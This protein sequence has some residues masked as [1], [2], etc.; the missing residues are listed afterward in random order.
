MPS[1]PSPYSAYN[2]VLYLENFEGD[3]KP[4]GGFEEVSDLPSRPPGCH[5]VDLALR[6]GVCN[7][8]SLWDCFLAE[9]G[10]SR[11]RWRNAILTQAKGAG[12]LMK[13][14]RLVSATPKRYNGP[15]PEG[16]GGDVAV[17]ELVLSVEYIEVRPRPQ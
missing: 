4:L 2:F 12:A 10:Q 14:W 13:S 8:R 11:A 7:A 15:T 6:R 16:I 9:R 3:Q 5:K 1:S 17:R